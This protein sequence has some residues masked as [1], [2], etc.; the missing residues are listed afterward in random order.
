MKNPGHRV[1]ATK[2][3]LRE[4][5]TSLLAEKPLRSITVKEL[6]ER[7]QINRGTFYAHYADV[8]DML[9]QIEADMEADFYAALEPVLSS[10][11]DLTPPTATAKVFQCLEMNADLC[12]ATLGPHGDREFAT[13]VI[14]TAKKRCE[15]SCVRFFP[16]ADKLQIETYFT[17][18][19]GGC[20]ALMERW[21]KDGMKESSE[22]LAAAAEQ[23]MEKGLGFLQ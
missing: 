10:A 7:A 17:F 14:E 1:Q 21:L 4:A 12:R 22:M 19:T 3:L 9:D 11:Y 18:I 16:N 15:E 13:R 8:Y 5:L 23:I 20:I 2:R 6:C